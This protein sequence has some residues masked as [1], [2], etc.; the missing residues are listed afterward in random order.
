MEASA[1]RVERRKARA[2]M[3][4]DSLVKTAAMI[5]LTKYRKL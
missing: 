3:A 2:Y 5:L 1:H 4:R